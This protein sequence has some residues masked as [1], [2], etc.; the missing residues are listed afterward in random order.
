VFEDITSTDQS[1]VLAELIDTALADNWDQLS[2]TMA[3]LWQSGDDPDDL[4]LAVR[5]L[6]DSVEE[7][8]SR[9]DS[10]W[11]YLAVAHSAVTDTFPPELLPL[12]DDGPVRIT[13]AVDHYSQSGVVRHRHGATQW[14]GAA[15]DLPVA[16][17]LRTRLWLEPAA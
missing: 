10:D 7:E 3:L 5:H 12:P 14:F 9:L 1:R 13:V 2:P 6:E 4:R 8:L 16:R 15:V 11:G 17:L